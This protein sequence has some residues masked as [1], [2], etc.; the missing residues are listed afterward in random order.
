[1]T[2]GDGFLESKGDMALF[3]AQCDLEGNMLDY[4]ILNTSV[5]D[6]SAF[7]RCIA[8][9][10]DSTIYVLGHDMC[11]GCDPVN[12]IG[13]I[14]VFTVDA[15]LNVLGY[16]V[17]A[18][19]GYYKAANVLTNE[20]GDLIVIGTK[21]VGNTYHFNLYV[22]RI[23]RE[24]LELTTTVVRIEENAAY[25]PVF[26][27]PAND[28]VSFILNANDLQN[29][30]RIIFHTLTGKTAL[31]K[32]VKGAGNTRSPDFGT[33]KSDVGQLIRYPI[34]EIRYPD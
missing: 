13:F 19:D 8:G 18:D 34:S 1:L 15:D 22:T 25:S 30:V 9:A 10:N 12:D 23:P 4:V 28:N 21:N 14:E 31:D 26:P 27:N 32:P 11:L 7:N 29:G 6:Q 5:Q 17:I 16:N 3:A 2:A 24:E 33:R 20:A